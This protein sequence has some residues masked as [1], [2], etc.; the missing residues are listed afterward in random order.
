VLLAENRFS[1]SQVG[2]R[3][4]CP[5]SFN[6]EGSTISSDGTDL[7]LQS[8]TKHSEQTRNWATWHNGS[9]H[10]EKKLKTVTA[11]ANL[12]HFLKLANTPQQGTER[13]REFQLLTQEG[14]GGIYNLQTPVAITNHIRFREGCLITHE[15]AIDGQKDVSLC[16]SGDPHLPQAWIH[17][18]GPSNVSISIYTAISSRLRYSCIIR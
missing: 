10:T 15:C 14:S 7:L 2:N 6:Q 16:R 8:L 17:Q 4:L 11:N 18:K 3:T 1:D 9:I 12:Y 13:W 5:A